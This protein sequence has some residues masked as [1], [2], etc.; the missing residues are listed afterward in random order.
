MNDGN[1]ARWATEPP[2]AQAATQLRA[3][4]IWLS[5]Q[6]AS[7]LE[8]GYTRQLTRDDE[9]QLSRWQGQRRALLTSLGELLDRSAAPIR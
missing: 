6:I 4:L 2:P 3:E 8:A 1:H 9:A 7:L 5:A